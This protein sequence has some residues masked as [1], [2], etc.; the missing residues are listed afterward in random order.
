MVERTA[1]NLNVLGA[2]LGMRDIE[3]PDR[4]SLEKAFGIEQA[5]VC[6]L[7]GGSI[8]A[9]G[10]LFAEAIRKRVAKTFI[11]VG[12][13]GHTTQALRDRVHEEYPQIETAGLPEAEV[14]AHYLREVH[15]CAADFLETKSTNCGNNITYLLDLI[16]EQ[17]IP[18]N[19]IILC[20]DAS[21]QRRMDA[22]FRLHGPKDCLV[23]NYAAYKA[24]VT[25]DEEGRLTYASPIHGMWDIPRYADLL[26]GEIPRLADTPSGYGPKGKGFIAHVE[27]PEKVMATFEELKAVFGDTVREANPLYASV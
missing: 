2:F 17:G 9:G 20:Q 7:F 23:I 26:M 3:R 4:A 10:D 12:G 16:R 11:I 25:A 24:C 22:G 5:D 18:C 15:G 8:L 21:M 6:V 13:A 1:H 19:S 14:F 27:V